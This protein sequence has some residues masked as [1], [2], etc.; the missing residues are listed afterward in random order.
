ME[1][2]LTVRV[3]GDGLALLGGEARVC[4]NPVAQAQ[5]PEWREGGAAALTMCTCVQASQCRMVCLLVVMARSLVLHGCRGDR[6][7]QARCAKVACLYAAQA[8][9][10]NTR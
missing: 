3:V 2:C 9:R 8:R 6:A 4:F 1:P 5:R 10:H 7:G